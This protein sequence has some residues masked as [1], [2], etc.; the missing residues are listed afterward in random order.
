MILSPMISRIELVS[1]KFY[2]YDIHLYFQEIT[3]TTRVDI[4]Y[5]RII[6]FLLC[7]DPPTLF[8]STNNQKNINYSSIIN[9]FNYYYNRIFPF[10]FCVL[11][12]LLLSD[13]ILYRI[14]ILY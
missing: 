4:Q 11:F 7:N 9:T 13:F 12:N 10:L 3:T 1:F 8:C 2:S 5:D 14:I 6:V